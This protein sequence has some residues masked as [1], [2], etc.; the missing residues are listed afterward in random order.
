MFVS[1]F[2]QIKL[3]N[4]SSYGNQDFAGH[5]H[6]GNDH[7]LFQM[8]HAP[9]LQPFS[10]R[11]TF[12]PPFKLAQPGQP[13]WHPKPAHI[14]MPERYKVLTPYERKVL[15]DHHNYLAQA[16]FG[17]QLQLFPPRQAQMH[18]PPNDYR[19]PTS[20][21]PSQMPLPA[22]D[23]RVPMS[24][25]E[26]SVPTAQEHSDVTSLTTGTTPQ[27]TAS[28]EMLHTINPRLLFHQSDDFSSYHDGHFGLGLTSTTAFDAPDALSALPALP[29]T[30][31]N[32]AAIFGHDEGS[33]MLESTTS[34]QNV[35]VVATPD[36][37][38]P[39]L[40]SQ[41]RAQSISVHSTHDRTPSNL[42]QHAPASASYQALSVR[43]KTPLASDP[44]DD[45][46]EYRPSASPACRT[47]PKKRKQS[48]SS[49]S[50]YSTSV[51]PQSKSGTRGAWS[52]A[53]DQ[54]CI[55]IMSELKRTRNIHNYS[56]EKNWEVTSEKMRKMG[57]ER[58]AS[59]VKMQW[60]RRLRAESG[61]DERINPNPEQ[62]RTG[63]LTPQSDK[64]KKSK[65][66][67][68]VDDS[69]V[70][71]LVV[72]GRVGKGRGGGGAVGKGH[73]KLAAGRR[74]RGSGGL[75]SAQLDGAC[76]DM[77]LET[78]MGLALGMDTVGGSGYG[79][80]HFDDA[81]G[82]FGSLHDAKLF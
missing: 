2:P 49:S 71:H 64:K 57:F 11:P 61:V 48:F 41:S 26:T 25:I 42:D 58:S 82:A 51:S 23:Y 43:Y 40:Q 19:M 6:G 28:P 31:P 7:Q 67:S 5:G 16:S 15:I 27:T 50:D 34:D 52:A 70:R 80:F 46:P 66:K 13:S 33:T 59:A 38:A 44:D 20:S 63:L 10:Y 4:M 1:S 75:L 12:M 68:K 79:G 32:Q 22:H 3:R 56:V 8:Q 9:S 69:P 55:K 73:G 81:L 60:T 14:E 29:Q 77:D 65:S 53:E 18:L 62:M 36:T 17:M 74:G 76:D 47:T 35:K 21:S 39:M 72:Q 54:A 30:V 78:D 24:S 37:E 45:D